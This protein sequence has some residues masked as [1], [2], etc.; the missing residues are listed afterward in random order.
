MP[1]KFSK[2]IFVVWLLISLSWAARAQIVSPDALLKDL[3]QSHFSGVLSHTGNDSIV[4]FKQDMHCIYGSHNYLWLRNKLFISIAGT[5]R[6]YEYTG[7]QTAK[8]IDNTCLEGYN[9]SAFNFVYRDTIFSLGGYGFWV[10]NGMLRYFDERSQEWQVKATN[11]TVSHR[12]NF[13]A[14]YDEKDKKIY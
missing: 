4:H 11:K 2:K 13:L 8:R 9:N 10:A 14:Y 5:G 7:N 3:Q 1:L 12:E 6:V